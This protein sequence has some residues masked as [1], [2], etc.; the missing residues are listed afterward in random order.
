[1][2]IAVIELGCV[3]AIL[4]AKYHVLATCVLLCV[5][6]SA[7]YSYAMFGASIAKIATPV[8]GLVIVLIRLYTMG[9]LR[10]KVD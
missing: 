2:I 7:I 5:E 4:F 1:M 10:E 9:K 8:F 3:I 6:I